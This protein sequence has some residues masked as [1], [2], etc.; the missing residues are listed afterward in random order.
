MTYRCVAQSPEGLVQQVA[1]S[2]L[3]H[4]Y[5]WYTCGRI[6]VD[7][8]P[9]RIDEKLIAKYEIVQT[10]RQRT[11]RKARGLANLQYI[12]FRNWFVLL[13][14][15]GNH[16][17]KQQELLRDC[18]RHPIR[19]EGYSISYR[20]AGITPK[21]G[22]PRKWHACVRIDPTTYRQLKQYFVMRAVHRNRE[23]LIE[24]FQRIPFARYAPIRRQLL[25]IQ[26]AV[27]RV[28]KQASFEEIPA[29]AIP[30]RRIIAR[31]FEPSVGA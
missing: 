22:G 21:G 13:A 7:K 2:Y 3:R 11:T 16:P 25:T 29:N 26:R 1:V 5:W 15:A 4:G 18:R 23:T 24:D 10:E 6:P 14:T 8:D 30:L 12:R 19:F 28:R 31:P 20:Q 27:N 9:T 17:I